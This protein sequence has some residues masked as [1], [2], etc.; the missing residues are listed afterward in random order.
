V[1]SAEKIPKPPECAL[2]ALKPACRHASRQPIDSENKYIAWMYRKA[3]KDIIP[4][5]ADF[6]TRASQ[7]LNVREKFSELGSVKE[8]N[9]YDLIALVVKEPFDMG[10][11][12]TLW[13]SDFT[14]NA[15]FYNHP[16][17]ASNIASLADGDPYGYCTKKLSTGSGWGGPY[18]KRSMQIT[19]YEP[20]ASFLRSEASSGKWLSLRNVQIKYGSNAN[21]L[22]G[23]LRDD[24]YKFGKKTQV[25]IL[26]PTNDD[27]E[28]INDRLK[29]A[30]R[31]RR[32]YEKSKKKQLREIM[33]VS[34]E[35]YNKRKA[36]EEPTERTLN[37]RARRAQARAKI[38]KKVEEYDKNAEK[39]LNL[40]EQGSNFNACLSIAH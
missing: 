33:S 29:G 15:A 7:S 5:A 20:H 17:L 39:A 9:F 11:K 38:Y 24:R 28:N 14:E 27:P 6:H 8:S 16:A 37:S 23:F 34:D 18:G 40:N 26:D 35:K 25:E 30:I 13:I 19:C 10:D 31:R 21:N 36:T 1:Y 12:I 4:D 32:D 22:E 2:I 3:R